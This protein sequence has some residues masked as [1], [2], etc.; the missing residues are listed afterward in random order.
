MKFGKV[1]LKTA[2]KK[3]AIFELFEGLFRITQGTQS[4]MLVAVANSRDVAETC[5]T[6]P[7]KKTFFKGQ[8]WQV[9]WID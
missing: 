5:T 7:L 6:N 4:G 9:S 1:C 3:G 8:L 2:K